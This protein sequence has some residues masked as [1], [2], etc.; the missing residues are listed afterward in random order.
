MSRK[1]PRSVGRVSRAIAPSSPSPRRLSRSRSRPRSGDPSGDRQHGEEPE[2]EPGDGDR[3][4]A[5]PQ[6]HERPC[7]TRERRIDDAAQG[8]VEHGTCRLPAQPGRVP[9]RGSKLTMRSGAGGGAGVAGRC[10][11]DRLAPAQARRRHDAEGDAEH[12][13]PGQHREGEPGLDH[14]A[15]DGGRARS[16]G[17]AG[18]CAAG[19]APASA[20]RSAPG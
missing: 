20:R 17:W 10:G 1:P 8:C 9:E 18:S 13:E 4:G 16:P 19:C 3:I 14:E 7:R 6:P 11:R 12:V 15:R 2:P 5:D